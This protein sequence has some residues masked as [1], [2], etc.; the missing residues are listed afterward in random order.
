MIKLAIVADDPGR[1]GAYKVAADIADGLDKSVYRIQWFFLCEKPHGGPSGIYLGVPTINISYSLISYVRLA[2]FPKAYEKSYS[3]LNEAL[4]AFLPDI[5]HFHTHA[6]LLSLV[7][8]IQAL[9]LNAQLI[10][11]DHSQRLRQ[12]ELS[13]LK[14]LLMIRVY[15]RLFRHLKVIFVSE[16][17]YHTALQLGYGI[18][19]KD[20]LI[21]NSV[22]IQK[23]CP[24]E[25][26]NPQMIKVVYLARLHHAKGHHLLL[27]AW[28]Q[29]PKADNLSLHLYGTEADGGSI[30]KRIDQESFP[31][32]VVFEGITF[33][34][35]CVLQN[36]QIGVFPSFREGLPLALLEMMACGLP[37]VAS[38][39]PEISNIITNGKDGLIFS[40]GDAHDLAAK[41]KQLI[42]DHALRKRLG[43]QAKE[44]ILKS[45]SKPVSIK[46]DEMYRSV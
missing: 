34:A 40:C 23:F 19:G 46:Y 20:F 38:D 7:S 10:Y 30:R 29:L 26:A 27:D 9:N 6:I 13:L 32:P 45:Y 37:V 18:K 5:I 1:G 43:N 31:N 41:I 39:I 11:T 4:E 12:G 14:E 36:A 24:G 2:F 44:T 28:Q 3:P 42:N 35:G 33:S 15:R 22:D 8:G 16:Y 21:S 25:V 17:A